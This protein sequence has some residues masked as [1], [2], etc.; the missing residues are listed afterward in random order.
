MPVAVY[1][2]LSHKIIVIVI[3]CIFALSKTCHA[4]A[5]RQRI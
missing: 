3:Y 2:N 4:H 5:F 1:K